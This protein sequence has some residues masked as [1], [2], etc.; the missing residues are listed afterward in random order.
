[1]P[2]HHTAIRWIESHVANDQNSQTL[3]LL[4]VLFV[5]VSLPYIQIYFL[6]TFALWVKCRIM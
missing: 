1:M 6:V 3:R 4:W 5:S 2:Q